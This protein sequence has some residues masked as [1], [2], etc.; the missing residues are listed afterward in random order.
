MEVGHVRMSI[1]TLRFF[2]ELLGQV[3]LQASHPAFEDMAARVVT[4]RKELAEAIELA[5]SPAA[6]DADVALRAATS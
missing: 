5:E 6:P 1:E 3:S 2:E 4:A